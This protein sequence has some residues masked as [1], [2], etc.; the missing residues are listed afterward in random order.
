[1]RGLFKG[2]ERALRSE[3]TAVLVFDAQVEWM[4]TTTEQRST[5]FLRS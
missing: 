1:M 4:P 2:M 3:E 5:V